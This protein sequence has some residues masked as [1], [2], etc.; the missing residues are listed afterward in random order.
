MYGGQLLSERLSQLAYD[1]IQNVYLESV[2]LVKQ[3]IAAQIEE[4][5]KAFQGI[6]NGRWH[7]EINVPGLKARPDM[8]FLDE[9][10]SFG[11]YDFQ[12][13]LSVRPRLTILLHSNE[14]T[15]VF[16]EFVAQ[17]AKSLEDQIRQA[18]AAESPDGTKI[19]IKVGA[20]IITSSHN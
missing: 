9:K 13:P 3:I 17:I 19:K 7:W 10:I 18:S 2:N 1:K 12:F 6:G 5:K 14:V 4:K 20:D 15:K 11:A 8:G 16:E